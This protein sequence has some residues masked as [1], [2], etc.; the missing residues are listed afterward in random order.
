MSVKE[1]IKKMAF[2]NIQS[3]VEGVPTTQSE[4]R[5]QSI[6]TSVRS[7]VELEHDMEIFKR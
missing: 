3:K 6:Q 2:L 5:R 4:E 7:S 1:I